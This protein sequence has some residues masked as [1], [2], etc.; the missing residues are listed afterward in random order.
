V[1]SPAF[2]YAHPH[3]VFS[4]LDGRAPYQIPVH[5]DGNAK[6]S[7]GRLSAVLSQSAPTTPGGPKV[8]RIAARQ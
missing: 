6:L 1:P 8:S 7:S 2:R 3:P 5:P 4:G